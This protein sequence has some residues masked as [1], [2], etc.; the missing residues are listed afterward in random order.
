M[1]ST[2]QATWEWP[3]YTKV[4]HRS[5]YPAIDPTNPANSTAGKVVVVTGKLASG[6]HTLAFRA[7]A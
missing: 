5:V 7:H 4:I 6:R 2:Q 3:G 1:G